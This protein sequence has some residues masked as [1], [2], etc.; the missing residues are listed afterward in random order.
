MATSRKSFH[1]DV[2]IVQAVAKLEGTTCQLRVAIESD[3]GDILSE[4]TM[5]ITECKPEDYDL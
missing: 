2:L 3:D 1:D 5:S 4:S